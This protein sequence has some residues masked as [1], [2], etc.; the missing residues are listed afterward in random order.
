MI[1]MASTATFAGPCSFDEI[2]HYIGPHLGLYFADNGTNL[3]F[4]FLN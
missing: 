3:L 2:F 1:H 4:V